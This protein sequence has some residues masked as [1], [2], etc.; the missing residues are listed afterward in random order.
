[1]PPSPSF[2]HTYLHPGDFIFPQDRMSLLRRG[3]LDRVECLFPLL[4]NSR[5]KTVDFSLKQVLSGDSINHLLV[6]FA[7]TPNSLNSEGMFHWGPVTKDSLH[8]LWGPIGRGPVHRGT[9]ARSSIPHKKRVLLLHQL[10]L[11]SSAL[12]LLWS[13]SPTSGRT[14]ILS[15][16]LDS[17]FTCLTNEIQEHFSC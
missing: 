7:G 12:F 13:C 5:G 10:K 14:R 11:G 8:S 9:V 2:L 16:V 17:V 1:M 4:C 6:T 15:E 3:F